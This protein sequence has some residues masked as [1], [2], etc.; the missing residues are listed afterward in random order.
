MNN[1]QT[2][3]IDKLHND[4]INKI[5]KNKNNKIKKTKQLDK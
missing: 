2:Q 3:T 1:T 5:V 4:N